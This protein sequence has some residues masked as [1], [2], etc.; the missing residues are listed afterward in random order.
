MSEPEKKEVNYAPPRLVDHI[1]I[2][3]PT[4]A[5]RL[6][7]PWRAVPGKPALFYTSM[8][9]R[10]V[11][12]VFSYHSFLVNVYIDIDWEDFKKGMSES[13]STVN[14]TLLN[15]LKQYKACDSFVEGES[16]HQLLE[17]IEENAI[18]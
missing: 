11:Y 5:E 13:S 10:N 9:G 14:Y 4:R 6:F 12:V 8:I 16:G 1:L 3:K 7:R 18:L 2:G 15:A 17:I